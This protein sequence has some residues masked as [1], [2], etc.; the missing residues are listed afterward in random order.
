MSSKRFGPEVL[1]AECFVYSEFE[2]RIKEESKIR[3]GYFHV[4]E[5]GFICPSCG[6]TRHHLDHGEQSECPKCG[7]FSRAY[8]NGLY[9]WFSDF[10]TK[11][12]GLLKL[13]E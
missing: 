7:L 2:I 3:P 1:G 9:C 5:I 4:K 6:T 11:I 10:K 8:G 12:R 13:S